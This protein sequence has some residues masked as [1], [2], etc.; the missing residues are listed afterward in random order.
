MESEKVLV[1]VRR[2]FVLGC[3]R[4][5]MKPKERRRKRPANLREKRKRE[6]ERLKGDGAVNWSEECWDAF[7]CEIFFRIP[8]NSAEIIVIT[9][10]KSNFPP[11][12][13]S[14]DENF[15]FHVV[16]VLA[17]PRPMEFKLSALY[18]NL[19]RKL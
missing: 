4:A 16:N 13:C 2:L 14:I 18:L 1:D 17:P 8:I 5:L 15:Q 12:H 10:K 19:A 11:A 6:R 9:L 3:T 7:G